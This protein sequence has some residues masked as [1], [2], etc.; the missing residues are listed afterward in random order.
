MFWE[1]DPARDFGYQGI[2][3]ADRHN[4]MLGR[5]S[6]DRQ[7]TRMGDAGNQIKLKDLV[8][9]IGIGKPTA[10][11]LTAYEWD[12]LRD[13]AEAQFHLNSTKGREAIR[14]YTL[15]YTVTVEEPS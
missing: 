9:K 8:T 2:L 11:I 1:V 10:M 13:S 15:E 4:S 7:P 6:P 14:D 5:I 3:V 12:D